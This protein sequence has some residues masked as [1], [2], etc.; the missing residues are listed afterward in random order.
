MW[1]V[2]WKVVSQQFTWD[3]VKLFCALYPLQSISIVF[4][5]LACTFVLFYTKLMH[6]IIFAGI[7]FIAG[8]IV[9]LPNPQQSSYQQNE[10]KITAKSV[11]SLNSVDADAEHHHLQNKSHHSQSVSSLLTKLDTCIV[12][13]P[14]LNELVDLFLKDF[15]H[16]WYDS[17]NVSKS[18]N[19]PN[20]VRSALS[21]AINRFYVIMKKVGAFQSTDG[22]DK[23]KI[24]K[25]LSYLSSSLIKSLGYYRQFEL[26]EQSWDEFTRLNVQIQ[27][28]QKN[29][30]QRLGDVAYRLLQ[31]LVPEDDFKSPCMR[32]IVQELLSGSVLWPIVQHYAQPEILCSII[33]RMLVKDPAKSLQQSGHANSQQLQQERRKSLHGIAPVQLTTMDVLKK[34]D[35]FAMFM[36]YMEQIN[37]PS[38]LRFWTNVDIYCQVSS[39]QLKELQSLDVGDNLNS[40]D[41]GGDRQHAMDLIRADARTVFDAHFAPYAELPI[42]L[43]SLSTMPS[44]YL[45]NLTLSDKSDADKVEQQLKQI[46][47]E[48]VKELKSALED[49]GHISAECFDKTKD[50][51]LNILESDYLDGFKKSE[52]FKKYFGIDQESKPLENIV[53][54]DDVQ[55]DVKESI[56]E[57][58]SSSQQSYQDNETTSSELTFLPSQKLKDQPSD[59]SIGLNPSAS[60]Q[61]EHDVNLVPTEVPQSADVTSQSN[62]QRVEVGADELSSLRQDKSL[63]AD[64]EALLHLAAA[65]TQLREQHHL[66]S[67]R[68]A[69]LKR[70]QN[71]MPMPSIEI[72]SQLRKVTRNKKD[73]ERQMAMLVTSANDMMMANNNIN[74][75]SSSSSQEDI[76]QQSERGQQVESVQ[77]QERLHLTA[78]KVSV[79]DVTIVADSDLDRSGNSTMIS[80]SG[81]TLNA[82]NSTLS[83]N[84]GGGSKLINSVGALTGLT[85]RMISTAQQN[86]DQ[87]RQQSN[88]GSINSQSLTKRLKNTVFLLQVEPQQSDLKGW[89]LSRSYP[90]ILALHT[91]LK[92]LFPKVSKID[93]PTLSRPQSLGSSSQQQI[94]D[95]EQRLRR[96]KDDVDHYLKMLVGD[97]LICESRAMQLFFTPD[98][99]HSGLGPV[100]RSATPATLQGGPTGTSIKQLR[101]GNISENVR[102]SLNK[103][104]R[105]LPTFGQQTQH[106]SHAGQQKDGPHHSTRGRSQS[107]ATS[108]RD[109]LGSKSPQRRLSIASSTGTTVYQQSVNTQQEL[110]DLINQGF[111]LVTEFFDLNAKNQWLR[112]KGLQIIRSLFL[113]QSIVGS[114]VSVGGGGAL[115]DLDTKSSNKMVSLIEESIFGSAEYLSQQVI[116]DSQ[117]KLW[118]QSLMDSYWPLPERKWYSTVPNYKP[119]A[120]DAIIIDGAVDKLNDFQYGSVIPEMSA[121]A[122]KQG[123]E[124][125]YYD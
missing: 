83:S 63:N 124:C 86:F 20:Q 16:F 30:V 92:T 31:A 112:R 10:F 108:V 3:D 107:Q 96:L 34:N 26:S 99:G 59:Q 76:D 41:I 87:L 38:Y 48:R 2:V 73:L 60:T 18:L 45:E 44:S 82:S 106:S 66:L 71:A 68:M 6:L 43:V 69:D 116:I 72:G 77:L 49:S 84:S 123:Y 102:E 85:K 80:G 88:T 17:L 104:L 111:L 115:S 98:G 13:D 25:T 95:N 120:K 15:I 19:F 57:H 100:L 40:S 27:V 47:E 50:Y 64:E 24:M 61:K 93:L 28:G 1:D 113:E 14:V 22:I 70:K 103:I 122:H 33:L 32:L 62:A 53:V 21:V 11:Q 5:V 90:D 109:P 23:R 117:M 125:S 42:K 54:N 58:A 12:L 29:Y 118:L 121:N 97:Q 105:S 65:I 67:D 81:N 7:G 101:S 94:N 9:F 89:L 46:H 35:L 36:E 39:L 37:A 56:Q 114:G 51:V 52:K 75:R 55:T 119:P 79:M 91:Q 4:T 110:P 8:Y 78:I 74:A